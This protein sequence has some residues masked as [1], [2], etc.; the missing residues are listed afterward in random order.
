[1]GTN[2]KSIPAA[3]IADDLFWVGANSSAPAHLLVT[4]AG[5]VLLDTGSIGTE[6]EVISNIESLGFDIRDVKHIIH[7]H[8]HYD[9]FGATNKIKEIS[10][11]K[12]YI[13]RA[14]A[15]AVRGKLSY[16][17]GSKEPF[18]AICFEPDI[19][20]N[21]G[22]VY[23]FGE[24]KMRFV[25]TPGHT[26]GVISMFFNVH[27]NGKE[28]LAGMFGG[29][30]HNAFTDEYFTQHSLPTSLREDY[31]RSINRIINEPVDFHIGNHPGNNNH[32]DKVARITED[33]N[34]FLTEKTW[35]PFLAERRDTLISKYGICLTEK[36]N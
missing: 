25:E 32:V 15:D 10:G 16:V 30:G 28:Y 34:P 33:N 1:M 5:L 6:D 27:C 12:T 9:H 21:D 22:D 24:T 7:S 13:G 19:L 23:K 35:V 11:A 36:Q 29:A 17:W 3:Q 14:D 2:K 8:G 20:I 18:P 26:P 4:S 31:V